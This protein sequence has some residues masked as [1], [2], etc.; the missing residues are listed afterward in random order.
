MYFSV[1]E[2]QRKEQWNFLV[3][4]KECLGDD[5]VIWGDMND[6]LC[7]EEKKGG[8]SRPHWTFRGFQKFVNDCGLVDLGFSGYPFTWRNNR[9][10]EDYI[11][12]LLDRVLA[13]PSWCR[14]FDQASV[15]H[16]NAV[17]SNHNALLLTLRPAPTNHRVPFRFDARWVEDD[18][19][20]HIIKQ[21]WSTQVQ[22]SRFFSIY[23]KIQSCRSSLTNWKRRKRAKFWPSYNRAK[24]E[25]FCSF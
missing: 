22:G 14:L 20:Q 9:R 6:L 16:L 4:Y 3:H 2:N 17:G 24:G 1:D 13:T 19:A 25:N 7:A 12:E 5:W 23:K 8:I 21:A 10:G 11:Q 15:S 18:E